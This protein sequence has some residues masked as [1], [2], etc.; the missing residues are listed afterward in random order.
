MTAPI[1][2]NNRER[3]GRLMKR[4]VR[5]TSL[6]MRPDPYQRREVFA[7]AER[8]GGVGGFAFISDGAWRREVKP[9]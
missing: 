2:G 1:R 6:D 8:V 4:K 7:A 5:T 9:C 3:I